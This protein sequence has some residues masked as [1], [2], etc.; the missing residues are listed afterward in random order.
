MY[1]ILISN[2]KFVTLVYDER[3]APIASFLSVNS[4][5][6]KKIIDRL[7]RFAAAMGYAFL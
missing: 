3:I 4:K 2:G 1:F 5:S 6:S 7:S